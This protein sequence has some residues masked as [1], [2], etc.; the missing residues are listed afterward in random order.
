M[1]GEYD[2]RRY[3]SH[4]GE[5]WV[6]EADADDKLAE[7]EARISDLESQLLMEEQIRADAEARL[8][9]AEHKCAECAFKGDG[10]RLVSL[11][12]RLA[13]AEKRDN[14]RV[15]IINSDHTRIAALEAECRRRKA[16]TDRQY[17][18]GVKLEAA[19]KLQ[20]EATGEALK[21]LAQLRLAARARGGETR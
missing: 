4:S 16:E 7:A 14:E 17:A 3:M 11:E 8:V 13:A 6:P 5:W 10:D 20:T 21:E 15:D 9:A 18:H 1:A 2:W 19:L 12:N